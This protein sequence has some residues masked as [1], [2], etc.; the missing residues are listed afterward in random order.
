VQYF[1]NGTIMQQLILYTLLAIYL[2]INDFTGK[3]NFRYL[4]ILRVDPK[5]NP[6]WNPQI[7]VGA[8][9]IN[10]QH[11]VRANSQFLTPMSYSSQPTQLR[12]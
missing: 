4:I 7:A 5:R 12:I 9:R 1:K 3:P 10:M 2:P 8:Q 11:T 6:T